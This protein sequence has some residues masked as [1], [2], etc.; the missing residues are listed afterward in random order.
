MEDC[1]ISATM[2][3]EV[4][5]AMTIDARAHS[6]TDLNLFRERVVAALRQA[7][8]Q[9]QELAAALGIGPQV[10]SRK[11]HGK[12]PSPL[13]HAEVRQIVK[14]LSDWDAIATRAEAIEMLS[15]LGLKAECFSDQDWHTPPLNRLD[16][17]PISV[18]EPRSSGAAGH[19]SVLLPIL[20]TSF[21][22]REWLVQKLLNRLRQPSVRLLTLLGTGGVGKTR[23]A[24][25]AA[26]E[27]WRDFADGVYFVSLAAISDAAL[28]PST[29]A[30]ALQLSEP[31][32]SGN[33][34]G[35][36]LSLPEDVLKSFLQDKELLLVLDN[37]EHLPGAAPFIGDLLRTAAGL[38]IMA[39]SRVVLHLYGEQEFDVPPLESCDP[40]HLPDLDYIVQFPAI[41][42]FVER[43]RAV[44]PAFQITEHNAATIARI[45]A[46]LDGLPLAI[47]LAAARTKMLSLS[48]ILEL[49]AGGA[50]QSLTFL[51]STAQDIPSRHQTL[52]D[53]LDWSYKLLAPSQQ[54][55]FRRLS[56][57]VGGWAFQAAL[58]V[59][60]EEEQAMTAADV[61]EEIE[62]LLDHSLVKR[63]WLEEAFP[64]EETEPRFYCLETVREYALG[65]LEVCGE[66]EQMQRQ[67]ALY[68][69]SLVE[70]VEPTLYGREQLAA[71]A[72]LTREQDNLR[73][74]LTWALAHD[75]AFIAQ[76]MCGAL[77][78]YWEAR[79]QFQEAQRWIEAALKM[80]AE[81]PH[82]VRAKLLMAASRQALWEIAC[83]RSRELALQ[84]LAL[85]E[86]DGDAVGKTQAL[87]QIG[88]T[89]HMQGEYATATSY[90]ED[91][92][93]HL[94]EQENWRVYA[95]TLS[96]LGAIALLQGN[97]SLAW[98]R[99]SEAAPLQREYSEP[100]LFNVTLVYLGVL[101]LVQGDMA[102]CIAYL[103]EGLLLARQTG[104]RYMLAT[105]LIAFGCASG[106]LRGPSFAAR[107]CSAAETLF[108]S[109]N[110]ALPA[111]YRP[112]YDGYLGAIRSQVDE[113]TWSDWWAE[114][115]LLS[116]DEIIALAIAASETTF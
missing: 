115:K 10:L 88:D 108:E 71:A 5:K 103:H 67:H 48:A 24:L 29:I 112:L 78:I 92:L 106:T 52:H 33:T 49:L 59:A 110:T 14:T 28:V 54:C 84:A 90:L 93:P 104:N 27:A 99:L 57:F 76:R 9:Q 73:A 34:G 107:I 68:F 23:L 75:E 4:Q 69:L 116:Q 38:K 8:R 39:T 98:T 56:V 3:F 35:Q 85:Y 66:R 37:V 81:I 61:L 7:G 96:R 22:G 65:Q 80:T 45:C 53:L 64:Q 87:F 30:Q 60:L 62:M 95:F 11:L 109:L 19:S 86:A 46:R 31:L 63:I 111:A 2:L 91:C 113:A 72:L 70:R 18:P 50:G 16:P 41:R 32:P 89:W 114:G 82:A 17:L 55:L 47:E 13:N 79:T 102:Q 15:L 100:G 42:L 83:E 36:G 40:D 94:R 1:R 97:F 44:N 101:A 43:A 105:D 74:A 20:P 25:E 26:R 51:R 6:L 12:K 77:G 21:I 58:A